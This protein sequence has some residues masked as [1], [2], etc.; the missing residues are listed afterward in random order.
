MPRF[1]VTPEQ[2]AAVGVAVAEVSA[3]LDPLRSMASVGTSVSDPP[4]T[5]AALAELGPQWASGADR[6][7]DD[8]YNL[9]TITQASA[10]LYQQ[11]DETVMGPP[12]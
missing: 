4:A 9:G 8:L 7:A 5:A 2:L 6:L 12:P 1:E 3:H 11:T 10:F